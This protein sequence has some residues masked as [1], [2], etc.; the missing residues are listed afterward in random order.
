MRKESHRRM[1]TQFP[2]GYAVL[3]LFLVVSLFCF[4]S[5]PCHAKS[6]QKPI[7]KS[8]ANVQTTFYLF[9]LSD[10]GVQQSYRLYKGTDSLTVL[11][12]SYYGVA[13]FE[14]LVAPGD[15][16]SLIPSGANPQAPSQPTGF[17]AAGGTDGCVTLSWNENPEPNIVDY[18]IYWATASVEQGQLPA[19]TDSVSGIVNIQRIQCNF[20][21]GTYYLSVRARNSFGMLSPLA[22][23]AQA[24]VTIVSQGPL[25][26]QEVDVSESSPGCATV[27]WQAG[28]GPDIAGYYV[29]YGTLSVPGQAAVYADSMD[30]GNSTELEICEFSQGGTFYFAVRTYTTAGLFSAY[31]QEVSLLI[32]VTSPSFANLYPAYGSDGVNVNT[33]ISFLVVDSQSGVDS[34][35]LSVRVNGNVPANISF[36]SNPESLQVSCSL[37]EPLPAL[38]AISVK[39][40]ARDLATFANTDSITWQF[41]T[42]D[43]SAVDVTPPVICCESPSSGSI[44]I[45]PDAVVRVT[46]SDDDSGIEF[47]ETFLLINGTSVEYTY[48]GDNQSAVLSY[49]GHDGFTNGDTVQVVVIAKDRSSPRNVTIKNDYWFV[50]VE[51]DRAI[52]ITEAQ[53]EIVPDGFWAH[54]P[55]KPLEIRNLPPDWTVRIFNTAGVQVKSYKNQDTAELNWV[56]ESFTNDFGARVARAL[57]LIRITDESGDVRRSGRFLVQQDP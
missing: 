17:A 35:A 4:A 8:V 40:V 24:T 31:S 23:E 25:P 30:A 49:S 48:D 42:G 28:G 44:D 12:T 10:D 2:V 15:S 16:Y 11:T 57:Y 52:V 45:D 19:Y 1:G 56:W 53:A 21:E 14:D 33:G 29:Y 46:V 51:E 22:A 38:T 55:D 20:T 50:I 36:G 13:T 6:P 18:T 7:G 54:D 43:T 5:S 27:S 3:S 39:V 9:N 26:P 47:T 32:D 41:T 37:A 34:L